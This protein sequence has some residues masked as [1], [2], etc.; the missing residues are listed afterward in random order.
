MGKNKPRKQTPEIPIKSV[1]TT[2]EGIVAYGD[3][4]GPIALIPP[5]YRDPLGL[6]GHCELYYVLWELLYRILFAKILASSAYKPS[7]ISRRLTRL[8]TGPLTRFM[9]PRYLWQPRFSSENT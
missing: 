8:L 2:A 6:I 9:P 1:T 7:H 5:S 4:K 3:F